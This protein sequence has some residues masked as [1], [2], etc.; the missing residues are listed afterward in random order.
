M[1]QLLLLTGTVLMLC[2]VTHRLTDKLGVPSL[3]VFIALGMCFGVDGIFRIPFDDY[4]MSETICS[5]CLIF[6]MFY[7]GFGTNIKEAKPVIVPA[8][9]LSTLGVVLTAGLTGGFVHLLFRLP[10]LESLLIGSVIA[11]TDAASVF[12]ILRSKSLNL[13][14]NTASL[15]EMESGSNDPMSYMLT[16]ILTAMMSGESLSV[17]KMLFLQLFFGVA[18]GVVIG[19]AAVWMLNRVRF[20]VTQGKTIA[21]FAVAILAYAIPSLLGGNG[22]LSVYLCGILMGNSYIPR[23][24][25][26][27]LF[28]DVLTG[29]AQMMIFFLLGLLVT[30]SQLPQ[31]VIPAALIMIF[32]TVIGRPVAVGGILAC[33]GSSKGQIGLVSWSGLR[34]V[35]SIVFAIYA[36]LRD[37]PMEYNLFNLVFCVVLLS[38]STQGTLLPWVSRKLNMIDDNADVHRTFTDYQEN[39]SISFIKIRVDQNH[40]FAGRQLKELQIP[41]GLLVVLVIRG[42]ETIVPNGDTRILPGDLLIT[43]AEEFEDRRNLTLQEITVDKG[44]KWNGKSLE[45]ITIPKGLLIVMIQRGQETIIPRG[46]TV[47][48]QGDVMVLAQL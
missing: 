38:I 37:I 39:S 7:G 36:V 35:A 5:V 43:A 24:R 17:P 15:L 20:N 19:R 16:V 40:K 27:V 32:M 10:L 29:V 21:V 47:I 11:S 18:G 8:V 1:N 31:V 42:K 26:M 41:K 6:I 25:D 3:L 12:S 30:P 33:F 4:Q 46:D 28:F 14:E 34:G 48:H 13:K 23:K 9:C 44:H 2:M 22:Y 45:Q